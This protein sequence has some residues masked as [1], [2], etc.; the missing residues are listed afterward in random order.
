MSK[1]HPRFMS[2]MR[3]S[4]LEERRRHQIAEMAWM[5][6]RAFEAR[7][8]EEERLKQERLWNQHL[9][10]EFTKKTYSLKK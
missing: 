6:Q 5:E 1:Y 4:E 8:M 9:L 10:A 7:K 2:T 3:P